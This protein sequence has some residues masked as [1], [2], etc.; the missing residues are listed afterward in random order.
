MRPLVDQ[1]IEPLSFEE[2]KATYLFK[3]PFAAPFKAAQFNGL[4]SWKLLWE[5]FANAH[6]D[7]WLPQNG[8][9]PEI[10]GNG[11]LSFEE[12]VKAYQDGRTILIRHAEK[13]HF[14]LAEIARDFYRTFNDPIDIQLYC[15]PPRQVGFDWHYDLEE[16]FVIQ[17]Q[18]EKEFRLF[19]NKDPLAPSGPVVKADDLPAQITGP[20]IRCHL[21][22]GD[23]LYIPAGYWHM[24]EAVTPSFHMSVG[25]MAS[26]VYGR[27][28]THWSLV[29]PPLSGLSADSFSRS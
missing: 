8:R 11:R 6:N 16:V 13:A 17:C 19:Q 23:W 9:L 4:V 7:C 2:F 18:G 14:K 27:K 3:R 12:A 5:I 10:N 28:S 1:L 26:N 15:T 25:V 29:K 21:K 24:A 20:E 22:A